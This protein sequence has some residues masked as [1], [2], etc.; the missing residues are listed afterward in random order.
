M[1]AVAAP[2]DGVYT[3]RV[4]ES[5]YGG[6]DGSL[7]LLHL[8]VFPV[9]YVAW[10]PG[11]RSGAEVELEWLG[12]PA[13]PFRTR[14]RLP[15]HSSHSGLFEERPQRDGVAAVIGV[16]LRIS[17]GDPI[18]ESEPNSE[19]G[20]ANRLTA[21]GAFAGRL[22]REEDVDWVRVEAPKGSAWRVRGWGRRL[23][24]PIDLVLGV[25]RDDAK[26][27]RLT[28]NDDADGPDA[29]VKVTTPD[30]GSFLVRVSD[31]QRRG[32]DRFVYWLDV[33]PVV[34]QVTVS[35]PPG[36]SNS[37]E[38]L[39]A[40]VPQGNRVALVFNASRDGCEDPAHL[41]F[42]NLPEGVR[43]VAQDVAAPMTGT[44]AVFEADAG[45]P[46]AVRAATVAVEVKA[47][48]ADP[49]R[50]G[51]LRQV[52]ELVYGQPNNAVYRTSISDRLPVAVVAPAAITVDV[53]PPTI[54]LA[55][56]G[57]LDL[58]V[59]IRRSEG[60]TGKVRLG[61]PFKPPGIGAPTTVDVDDNVSEATYT[62]NATAD[63]AVGE[64]Q[65]VVT[66]TVKDKDAPET[67][68]SS[69]PVTIRVV[70]PPVE[71]AAEKATTE[72]GCDAKIVCKVTKPGSFEGVAKVKL[73]GL[74]A[75]LE[76]PE[77]DLPAGGTELVFPISV[78][79]DAPP[80]RH[81]NIF[82]QVRVP[83]RVP[84]G[85]AWMVFA[86]PATNLRIDTPLRKKESQQP[87]RDKESQQPPLA[88]DSPPK[89]AANSAPAPGKDGG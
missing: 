42:A 36:R 2:A 70:E 48:G 55:R 23:G 77:L 26:R 35:V 52:T 46:P 40:E 80:G 50:V 38:R 41:A 10:P 47:E 51:E 19:P 75:K 62:I 37:Q 20:E 33:E 27:E 63:A 44:V 17:A 57:S 53:D 79:A 73:M 4:R 24:S 49:R 16:P 86:T 88:K 39:V 13:G 28:G 89:A 61:F 65:V 64:R 83:Q 11:G 29:E 31:H 9:P 21:P 84:E 25:H 15:E 58:R 56:R 43:V 7:Y 78:P 30:Q 66:A 18:V 3:V 8:G 45:A 67:W 85:E 12:D 81:D 76:A 22:N 68:V 82:C 72:Q 60:F 74:P 6:N 14:L 71:I 34:P 5:T 69:L 54:P 59:R 1:L 87:P 32:D